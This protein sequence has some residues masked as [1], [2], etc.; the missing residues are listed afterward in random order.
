MQ[1]EK[2][3]F[4]FNYALAS[5]GRRNALKQKT[6]RNAGEIKGLSKKTSPF[7][8]MMSVQAIK[9]QRKGDAPWRKV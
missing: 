3:V 5:F 7:G 8:K 6:A 4:Y 9:D 1:S 2:S